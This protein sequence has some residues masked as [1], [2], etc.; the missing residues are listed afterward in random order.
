MLFLN[1]IPKP[2]TKDGKKDVLDQITAY[3]A[4]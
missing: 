1:P 3:L 4:Q 2:L